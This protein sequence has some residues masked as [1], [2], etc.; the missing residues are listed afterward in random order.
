MPKISYLPITFREKTHEIIDIANSIIEAYQKEGYDLTLRQLYYQFVARDLLPNTDKSYG[1][2][3][4]IINRARLAG[5]IDWD[6]IVDRTRSIKRNPHWNGPSQILE[7]AAYSF[8]I[9]TR[10]NQDVYLEVWIE[11]D[12][13]VGVISGICE[14]LDVP[15]FSCRGYASQ[16]SMWRASERIGKE[17][18]YGSEENWKEKGNRK[19]IILHLGDHDPSGIDMTRDIEDRLAMF[20][21][22]TIVKRIALTMEQIDEYNPPPNPA[23]VTDTR[24]DDY[25]NQYGI[26]CWE[27]DALDPRV[28]TSLIQ[29]HIDKH[30]E[31]EKLAEKINLQEEHRSKIEYLADNWNEIQKI[32]EGN[33]NE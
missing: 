14:K 11:K 30:T 31:H 21:V 20:R 4:G 13:L 9:D 10:A 12:A 24:Y 7:S 8:A 15:Y 33:N 29:E 25:I 27:L 32:I 6:A 3:G 28:I 22:P 1:K 19:A 23:K 26:E 2:L 18:C 5:I 17:M 16:S